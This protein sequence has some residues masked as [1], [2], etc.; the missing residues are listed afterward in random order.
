MIT[1]VGPPL[2]PMTALPWSRFPYVPLVAE[3]TAPANAGETNLSA[4]QVSLAP[5]QSPPRVLAIGEAKCH[6]VTL[7]LRPGWDVTRPTA[8]KL[9]RVADALT[10]FGDLTALTER[11]RTLP[12][13]D[14]RPG[15]L[16]ATVT[17]AERARNAVSF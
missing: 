7:T 16:F 17:R 11:C 12:A 1:E 10:V 13:P 15:R 4:A 6:E 9:A 2:W 3:F 5:T 8:E 14:P